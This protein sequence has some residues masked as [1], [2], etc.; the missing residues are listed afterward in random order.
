M[1]IILNILVTSQIYVSSYY[2][3]FQI[4]SGAVVKNVNSQSSLK[5][6][7]LRGSK[8][9]WEHNF[10]CCTFSLQYRFFPN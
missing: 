10:F 7:L 3:L 9:P 8:F 5:F 1:K 2:L 6:G 4:Q